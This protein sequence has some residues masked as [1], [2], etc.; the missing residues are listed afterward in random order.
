MLPCSSADKTSKGRRQSQAASTGSDS[1]A[2]DSDKP[3][4]KVSERDSSVIY[5][6]GG[7]KKLGKKRVGGKFCLLLER[8]YV[9]SPS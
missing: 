9:T 5:K 3:L 7:K 4:L 1:D 8:L 6:P 2:M